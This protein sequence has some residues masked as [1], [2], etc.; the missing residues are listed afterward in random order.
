MKKPSGVNNSTHG[1]ARRDKLS[2]SQSFSG[3]GNMSVELV[4]S[5][6]EGGA[7][8]I[9]TRNVAGVSADFVFPVQEQSQNPINTN[10]GVVTDNINAS[11][12][13]SMFRQ[14]EA[15][16]QLQKATS[17]KAPAPVP[18]SAPAPALLE[19]KS[20]T[21]NSSLKG[22]VSDTRRGVTWANN[23]IFR[24]NLQKETIEMIRCA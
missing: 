7:I 8:E 9:S 5:E 13:R 23:T 14:L 22:S 20:D 17:V 12:S 4:F 15:N 19:V 1:V 18:S 6:D 11:G 2:N 24:D 16:A 3:N 21:A 10:P